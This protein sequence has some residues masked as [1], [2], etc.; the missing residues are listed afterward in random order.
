MQRLARRGRPPDTCE[1][2]DPWSPDRL[3]MEVDRLSGRGLQLPNF[4]LELS[5]RLHRTIQF[6][7]VCWY[8]FDPETM[9]MTGHTREQLPDRLSELT[10][11]EYVEQ[12][13]NRY[14]ELARRRVPVGVLALELRGDL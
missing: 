12:D 14:V 3:Q 13:A 5:A 1:V 11:N 2:S 4:W 8:T 9:L 7:G 10:Y 6:D